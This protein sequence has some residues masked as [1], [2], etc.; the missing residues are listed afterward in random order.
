MEDVELCAVRRARRPRA[1]CRERAIHPLKV[2]CVAGAAEGV[3]ILLTLCTSSRIRTCMYVCTSTMY[4]YKVLCM[5][6]YIVLCIAEKWELRQVGGGEAR[7]AD[8]EE[9]EREKCGRADE[10]SLVYNCTVHSL[11]QHTTTSRR[12]HSYTMNACIFICL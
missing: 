2:R 1:H 10:Q 9:R 6:K 11:V 3:G 8:R 4:K 5:Y 12:V 7:A